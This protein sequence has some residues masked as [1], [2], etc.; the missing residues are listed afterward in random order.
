MDSLTPLRCQGP[1]EE[2]WH[3]LARL[4]QA[5]P[6]LQHLDLHGLGITEE[7][8]FHLRRSKRTDYKAT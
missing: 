6:H 2:A 1:K 7:G 3:E 4:V 5:L 8:L